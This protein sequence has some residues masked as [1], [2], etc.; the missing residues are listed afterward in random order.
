[1]NNYNGHHPNHIVGFIII[2]FEK[3]NSSGI[4]LFI[5]IFLLTKACH[6]VAE[7]GIV[8]TDMMTG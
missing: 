2:K 8:I 4:F 6:L 3:I 5:L 7:S 1:M